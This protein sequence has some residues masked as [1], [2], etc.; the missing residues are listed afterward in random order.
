MLSEVISPSKLGAELAARVAN[1]FPV[2]S[3][4]EL[5]DVVLDVFIVAAPDALT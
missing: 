5:V 3:V 4:V 2:V 1:D